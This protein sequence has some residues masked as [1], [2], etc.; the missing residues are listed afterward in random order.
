[1][2]YV[3]HPGTGSLH[4]KVMH[5]DKQTGIMT[6]AWRGDLMF[7][8]GQR[9][10]VLAKGDTKHKSYACEIR[11]FGEWSVISKFRM[12]FFNSQP[13][14]ETRFK[15]AERSYLLRAY[16]AKSLAGKTYLRLALPAVREGYRSAT[17]IL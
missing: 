15:I 17:A 3:Q 13:Y 16:P 7:E 5:D 10:Q 2:N 1:M 8:S 6:R 12:P 11:V 9:M 14:V 4:L